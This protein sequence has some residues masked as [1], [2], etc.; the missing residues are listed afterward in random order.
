MKTKFSYLAISVASLLLG[1]NSCSNNEDVEEQNSEPKSIYLK[2]ANEA[3]LTYSDGTPI[4]NATTVGLT[5]GSLYFTNASGAILAYYTLSS[6]NTD[7][8]TGGTNIKLSDIQG[9]QT[10]SNLPGQVSAVHVVGNSSGLPTTGNI[11]Q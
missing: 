3:P 4:S 1:L 5:S 9:G 10:I 11:Q 8:G 2:I 7:I 6:S